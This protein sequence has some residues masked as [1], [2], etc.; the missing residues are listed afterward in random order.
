[1]TTITIKPIDMLDRSERI[2]TV[3]SL[4]IY[5]NAIIPLLIIQGSSEG[6]GIPMSTF[7]FTPLNL[8]FLTNYLITT[9]LLLLRWKNTLYFTSKN[10]LFIALILMVPLSFFWSAMPEKTYTGSVGMIGTTLFGLYLASRFTLKE[11]LNLIAAS[12][13]IVLAASILFIIALP[14]YGIM[15]GIH[16]G[17][18][19]GVFTHKNIMGKFMVLSSCIFLLLVRST[20]RPSFKNFYPWLGFL[21]SVALMVGSSS[22]NAIL[23]GAFLLSLVLISGQLFQLRLQL[24]LP[25][26]LMLGLFAWAVSTWFID[27]AT[28]V[29]EAFGKD[30]TLTGRTD[31][32]TYAIDKILERPWLG[33][34]FAGFW[35]GLDGES[36][37]VVRAVRWATP[38]AHNGYLD[39]ILQLGMIGFTLFLLVFWTTLLRTLTLIISDF[40]WEHLWPLLFMFYM[41]FANFAE[42]ALLSQNDFFWIMI[43]T[44]VFS[45]SVRYKQLVSNAI[46]LEPV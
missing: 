16:A 40:R 38:N 31:I 14:K 21:V 22:T 27:V 33:Y 5:M 41:V 35:H 7:N 37:Y 34:G 9:G 32:W 30:L 46:E 20:G 26:L 43:T 23:S 18:P 1:M 12:F 44:V 28:V 2:F 4:V 36:S 29:V 11:Q 13:G 15:G 39:F 45:V 10:L 24:L 3:I 25:I 19:R 17:L 8:L 6:D 42:G